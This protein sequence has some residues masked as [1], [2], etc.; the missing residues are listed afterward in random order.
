MSKSKTFS[1]KAR[2]RRALR[3]GSV[4]AVILKEE[5][6]TGFFKKVF[7]KPAEKEKKDQIEK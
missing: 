4:K 3:I 6:K 7:G 5:N 2:K 1:K